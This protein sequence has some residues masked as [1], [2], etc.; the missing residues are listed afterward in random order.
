MPTMSPRNSWPVA[1]MYHDRTETEKQ[2]H[3]NNQLWSNLHRWP[4]ESR[5][6]SIE[7]SQKSSG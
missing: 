3:G 4:P 7:G 2:R 5:K 6:E 1:G